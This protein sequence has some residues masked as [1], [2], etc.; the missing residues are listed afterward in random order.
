MKEKS[1]FQKDFFNNLIL[2][3]KDKRSQINAHKII[4]K[5]ISEKKIQLVLHFL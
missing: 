2:S 3:L 4:L 1:I 5:I